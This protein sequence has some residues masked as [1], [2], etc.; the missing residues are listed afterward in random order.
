MSAQIAVATLS[1][2]AYYSLVV[3]LRRRNVSFLSLRPGDPVPASVKVVITTPQERLKIHHPKVLLY[4]EGE[5]AGT[6]VETALQTMLG[7][8]LYKRLVVG[9]DPGKR[10]GM[11]VL[12]DEKVLRMLSCSSVR[13]T[14][15]ALMD[16]LDEIDSAKKVVRI[17]D[18][19]E[20][21]RRSLIRML[22]RKLPWNVTVETVSERDTTRWAKSLTPRRKSLLDAASA[23]GIASRSGR[24]IPRRR[25]HG[26][27]G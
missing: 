9:I 6:I 18:G 14:A 16:I 22:E 25:G 7:R 21:Y 26:K 10:F 19:G 8:E 23:I 3:E 12:G 11:A 5:N 2:R 4:R 24:R 15:K 1:G 27:A 20:P 17:G 13:E